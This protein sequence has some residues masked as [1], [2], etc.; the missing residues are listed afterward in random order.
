MLGHVMVSY[1]SA[2]SVVD[3]GQRYRGRWI[4]AGRGRDVRLFQLFIGGVMTWFHP[5]FALLAV[6]AIAV[7]THAIVLRRVLL[8]WKWFRNGRE[9]I[10]HKIGAII[11]DF[12]G[13]VADTMPFLTETA[14]KLMTENYDV[15]GEVAE[16]RYLENTGMDFASHRAIAFFGISRIFGKEEFQQIG[17]TSVGSLCD[18]VKL[19]DEPEDV[20]EGF[21]EVS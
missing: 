9:H 4:A 6:L 20:Y 8:T 16:K 5:I 2:K 15:S 10:K 3:F 1:T 18:L 13:T 11:F 12:D 17:A 21:E 14:V 7:Q 19:L